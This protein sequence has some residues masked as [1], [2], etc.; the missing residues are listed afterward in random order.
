MTLEGILYS[1]RPV[2]LTRCNISAV[3]QSTK[4]DHTVQMVW[5]PTLEMVA[6]NLLSSTWSLREMDNLMSKCIYVE[7]QNNRARLSESM[8]AHKRS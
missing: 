6:D 4:I 2:F 3:V 5:I 8:N 1:L 7:Q